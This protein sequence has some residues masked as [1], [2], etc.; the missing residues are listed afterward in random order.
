[1]SIF[2]RFTRRGES[3]AG[4]ANGGD[5]SP[6]SQLPA[7]QIWNIPLRDTSTHTA[8]PAKPVDTASEWDI[9]VIGSS[10]KT[11]EP[12]GSVSGKESRTTLKGL[13]TSRNTGGFGLRRKGKK[14]RT[15]AQFSDMLKEEMLSAVNDIQKD[16]NRLSM[17]ETWRGYRKG[18]WY[19]RFYLRYL[20]R[21]HKG[22]WKYSEPGETYYDC[23]QC[24]QP[25]KNEWGGYWYRTCTV[26]RR[27]FRRDTMS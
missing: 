19:K 11:S 14:P 2:G 8:T 23:E 7:G 13:L 5:T 12:L 16:L 9:K 1:M 25:V 22:G 17:G 3:T 18:R 26:C 15:A 10:V 21:R 24:G 20:H 4:V 6:T 27:S